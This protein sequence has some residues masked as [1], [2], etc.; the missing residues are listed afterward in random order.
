[1]VGKAATF[2]CLILHLDV[3]G[4]LNQIMDGN[5][6]FQINLKLTFKRTKSF[7]FENIKT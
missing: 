4:K 6:A 7:Y 1:M 3:F 5:D 2:S